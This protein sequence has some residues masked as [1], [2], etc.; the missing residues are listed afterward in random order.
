M[1]NRMQLQPEQAGFLLNNIYLPSLKNEHR[2]TKNV[3]EAIPSDKGDY[4]P[5]DIAMSAIDLAWHIVW[6]ET[7]FLKAILNGEFNFDGSQRPDSARTPADVIDWYEKNFHELFDRLRGASPEQLTKVIDFRGR[8]QL[9]A[10]MYLGPLMN[11]SIHHRG[12][13]SIYLRPMGSKV[14]AIYGESYETKRAAQTMQ[15]QA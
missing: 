13:L 2:T 3:L 5:D 7:M 1:L 14:P 15:P 10:V 6:A 8:L 9:P 12:Q 11:H 4:R